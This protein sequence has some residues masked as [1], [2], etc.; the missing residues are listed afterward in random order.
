[1]NSMA[2]TAPP[3]AVARLIVAAADMSANGRCLRASISTSLERHGFLGKTGPDE[4]FDWPIRS[5]GRDV[6][7]DD[8]RHR[9]YHS[10]QRQGFVARD[11]AMA[12]LIRAACLTHYAD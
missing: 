11:T 12:D 10:R 1:M 3:K 9:F 8:S 5:R 4:L 7:F 2:P 6:A